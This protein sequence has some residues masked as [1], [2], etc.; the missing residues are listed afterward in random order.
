MGRCAVRS[1]KN[2][3]TFLRCLRCPSSGG[4]YYGASKLL[5][6]KC[7]L[8]YKVLYDATP[9]PVAA[10]SKAYVCGRLVAGIAVSN[11]AGDMD[12]YLLRLYVVFC[13]GRG[14]CDGLITRSD[15]SYRV[16]LYAWSQ[17]PRKG[18]CVP[19]CEPAGKWMMMI[20]RNIPEDS[21]LR[22]RRREYFKFHRFWAPCWVVP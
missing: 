12:V 11:P 17:K 5:W 4:K 19:S 20:W 16:S 6:H 7:P 10:R 1:C 18:P 15:E 13:V 21:H 22:T 3:R 8:V 2:L 9:I 14:L